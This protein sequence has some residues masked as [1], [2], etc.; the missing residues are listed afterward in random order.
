[1]MIWSG[2]GFLPIVFLI[3]FAFGFSAGHIGPMSDTALACTFFWTG[4]ASGQLSA[5]IIKKAI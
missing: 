3:L 4:L 1:M 2:L 5:K